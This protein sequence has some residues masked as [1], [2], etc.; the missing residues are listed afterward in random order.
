M[1]EPWTWRILHRSAIELRQ[2]EK[3]DPDTEIEDPEYMN[4]ADELK[5]NRLFRM[6]RK[7]FYFFKKLGVKNLEWIL[8]IKLRKSHR[9]LS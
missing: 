5:R 8:K 1:P 2:P 3:T 6:I 9:L 7:F 4:V